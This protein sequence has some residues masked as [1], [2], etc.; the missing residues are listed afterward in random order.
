MSTYP[1]ANLIVIGDLNDYPDSQPI[2]QLTQMGLR[3]MMTKI[4]RAVRYTYIYQGVS[5][6]LDYVFTSPALSLHSLE[7]QPV[8]L[9]ADFPSIYQNQA[10]TIYRSSDHDP[11]LMR[12][13][14]LSQRAYLPVVWR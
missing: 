4:H 11:V 1:D 13:V 7:P 9:N 10:E 5:Q 2:A 3:N 14:F 12:F 8:H 6:V